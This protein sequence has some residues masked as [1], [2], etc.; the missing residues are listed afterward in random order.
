MNYLITPPDQLIETT[1]ELPLSKS[2]SARRI[3][4]DA[5]SNIT[6]PGEVAHCDDI[7]ALTQALQCPNGATAHVNASGTALRFLTAYFAATPGK[8]VVIDGCQRI[9]E[10]P[11]GILLEAL[12]SLGADIQCLDK[13]GHAPIAVTG[14]QL[15]GGCLEIDASVSSQFVS[16]L[17]MV[18]PTMA[19][20]LNMTLTNNIA[21][22][23]Y[24]KMTVDMM[25]QRGAN[26]DINGQSISVTPG[27]YITAGK[28]VE[29]D[30]SAA[31]YWYA[32]EAISAGWITLPGLT[33]HSLQG[34]SEMQ[35]IGEKIGVITNFD[36]D[37]APDSAVLSAT[38]D[39]YGRLSLDMTAT[40]DLVP[41]VAVAACTVGIPFVFTG[42]KALH[43]KECDRVEALQAQ[44]L[45]LGCIVEC[46]NN[47]TMAWN[48]RRM[49]VAQRPVI[50]TYN[51]HRMA[52]AF[53]PVAI[54]VPG[55]VIKD[56]EVVDKSY[57]DFWKHLTEAGFT[58][59]Q[60]LEE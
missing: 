46:D 52:M 53:A 8:S 6:S 24:I 59:E 10:R 3:L 12:R 51:D 31:S 15:T 1:V 39:I 36:D 19:S 58:L 26:V 34:D 5:I 56:I 14:K 42:V 16:A 18:A 60:W 40:P 37:D 33:E 22:A 35:H 28:A 21:S 25:Q 30:W 17:L 44:L 13:E 50:D 54:F 7:T 45:K 47:D 20:P 2:I 11:L 32:I 49:P 48:G 23:P 57:P 9:R 43:D 55:I 29:R 4:I 41:A 38:P 27:A